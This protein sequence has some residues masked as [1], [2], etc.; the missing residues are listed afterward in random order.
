MSDGC[1]CGCVDHDELRYLEER[2]VAALKLLGVE[3][4]PCPNGAL[5]PGEKH[6]PPCR[7]DCER[8]QGRCVVPVRIAQ[9][10]SG[11]TT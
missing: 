3:E 11:T 4:Q 7:Y 6:R 9:A 5:R 8:C 1:R 10:A 2:L